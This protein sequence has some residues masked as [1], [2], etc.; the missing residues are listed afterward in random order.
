MKSRLI[1]LVAIIV[2]VVHLG[3]YFVTRKAPEPN[4][5]PTGQPEKRDF[6]EIEPVAPGP[7]DSEEVPESRTEEEGSADGVN[8]DPVDSSEPAESSPEIAL[9]EPP[10]PAPSTI[11]LVEGKSKL[12]PKLADL[13]KRGVE[14]VTEERWEDAR[15]LYL[16][17][18]AKAPDNALAYANLG[19]AEYQ[20]GNHL[21]ASGNLRKS[22]DINPSIAQNWQTLGLIHFER[23]EMELAISCLSRAIH[24][25]PS[26]ARSRLYLSA[27]VREYGWPQAA[28][29]ELER[30][31]E[32]DP[33]LADAHFNLA[34]T[35]LDAK[36]PRI[37]LARRHYFA[38]IEKGAPPA[39]EVEAALNSSLGTEAPKATATSDSPAS[40][41]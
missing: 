33:D 40:N 16:E 1:L 22:L 6:A 39:P 17:L 29:T 3:I 37:E 15:K 31:V 41:E 36:P 18:V 32:I 34:L 30:A 19:V 14:A 12:D 9:A 23:G 27:V 28:E 11:G 21:A 2:G 5:P 24:E 35:Y 38:A 10:A 7:I 4:A 20:L 13:A 26:N 8:Q 25:E